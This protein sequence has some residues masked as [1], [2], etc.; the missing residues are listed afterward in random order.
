[1]KYEFLIPGAQLRFGNAIF[2]QS[3]EQMTTDMKLTM[4]R[5]YPGEGLT[6]TMPSQGEKGLVPLLTQ[7]YACA[8]LIP[9]NLRAE[10]PQMRSAQAQVI[11]S[12]I[13]RAFSLMVMPML[14]QFGG[15]VVDTTPTQMRHVIDGL[16]RHCYRILAGLDSYCLRMTEDNRYPS[17][18]PKDGQS[19]TCVL[20][21]FGVS[22]TST[23][24]ALF[25]GGEN[26][27]LR[28]TGAVNLVRYVGGLGLTV[29]THC[30]DACGET[31]S[32]LGGGVF[33]W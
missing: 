8:L 23:G 7:T 6:G 11:S 22:G 25:D 15:R 2:M 5:K 30:R 32:Q 27:H 17:L 16:E 24:A 31:T 1:M 9:D 33:D 10:N 14:A 26:T 13:G 29:T 4:L 20:V 28:A 21:V 19:R 3:A 12:R 18:L